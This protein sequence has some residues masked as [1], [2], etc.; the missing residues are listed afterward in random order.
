M[1]TFNFHL[2]VLFFFLKKKYD[3]IWNWMFSE[4]LGVIFFFFFWKFGN[5]TGVAYRFEKQQVDKRFDTS[6]DKTALIKLEWALREDKYFPVPCNTTLKLAL[7]P[8]VAPAN[9]HAQVG[10]IQ[11]K[12][13]AADECQ[14]CIA[15]IINCNKTRGMV[16]SIGWLSILQPPSLSLS[17]FHLV[18]RIS[19]ASLFSIRDYDGNTFQ[20]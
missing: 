3:G 13:D 18:F 17:P 4:V 11:S 15:S 12:F 16:P 5:E 14:D 20:L 19:L 9:A 7:F 10:W 1:F 8:V 2:C 6:G